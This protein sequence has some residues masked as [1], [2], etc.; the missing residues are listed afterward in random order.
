MPY[1]RAHTWD[2]VSK[3]AKAMRSMARDADFDLPVTATKE[4]QQ[5]PKIS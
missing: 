2:R 4:L 1:H 5:K 3:G